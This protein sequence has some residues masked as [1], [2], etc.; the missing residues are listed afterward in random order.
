MDFAVSPLYQEVQEVAANCDGASQ[1]SYSAIIHTDDAGN[2]VT[3]QT[4]LNVTS[5]SDFV[6]NYADEMG[7]RV[8]V[9]LGQ[10]AKRIYPNRTHLQITLTKKTLFENSTGA[11][12]NAPTE[13]ERYTAVLVE[14]RSA[15]TQM[16]G[17][18]VRTE[19]DLDLGGVIELQ[20]Q[21]FSKAV[22]RLRVMQCGTGYRR[23]SVEAIIRAEIT[24]SF[25]RVEIDE[26]KRLLG[27]TMFASNN[28]KVYEQVVV[29][30]A[31]EVVN[32]P[33]LLQRNYG[34]YN[35]GLGTYIRGRQWYVYPLYDTSVYTK[36][37]KMLT[38]YI[39]PKKRFP[40]IERTYRVRGD[41]IAILTSSDTDFRGDND[42]NYVDT[43]NGVRFSDADTL[44]N[45]FVSVKD[46][47][48]VASRQSSSNELV[49]A[50]QSSGITYAPISKRPITANHCVH[51]SEL[52]AKRG[53]MLQLFWQNSD[54]QLLIPG[55]GV[56]IVYFDKDNLNEAY[57]VLHG[58]TSMAAKVGSYQTDKHVHATKL[59]IF[60][61]LRLSSQG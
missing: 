14:D 38:V 40:E 30:H 53:G 1:V 6:G 33:G 46:N 45:N 13:S 19:E 16:Q 9:T 39:L 25:Q 11:D 35:A 34:V 59:N 49:A 41:S 51:F 10:Y 15:P 54:P 48:A 44:F 17:F 5:T 8:V 3:P 50:K 55:Q 56:R 18:E 32:L 31:C 61:T 24:R 27:V 4:V 36:Q 20:F 58:T 52:A 2:S 37:T 42:I 23:N 21:I 47:K 26:K 28:D 7:V 60:T 57:G 43:G 22:E 29:D 12:K